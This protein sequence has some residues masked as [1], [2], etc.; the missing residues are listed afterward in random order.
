M[1]RCIKCPGSVHVS[2]K[3]IEEGIRKVIESGVPIADKNLYMKRLNTCYSCE[4]LVYGT[5][6]MSC[7]CI[8]RIRA[9]NALRI[10]PHE[11][12]SKW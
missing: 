10:C 5:T 8:V 7:G 9:L 11:S 6:C 12:G 2:E 4:R 3:E 1:K